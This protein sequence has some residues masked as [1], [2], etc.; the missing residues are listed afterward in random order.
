[1][2]WSGVGWDGMGWDGMGDFFE[3]SAQASSESGVRHWW[4]CRLHSLTSCFQLGKAIVSAFSQC[5]HETG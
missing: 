4:V 2:G 5:T 3:T 1:M